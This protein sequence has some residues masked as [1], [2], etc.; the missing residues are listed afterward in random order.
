MKLPELSPFENIFI[1]LIVWFIAAIM[2]LWFLG[3]CSP[4][5]VTDD[6]PVVADEVPQVEVPTQT[7]Y[8][9]TATPEPAVVPVVPTDAVEPAPDC[10]AEYMMGLTVGHVPGLDVGEKKS[11]VVVSYGCLAFSIDFNGEAHLSGILAEDGLSLESCTFFADHTYPCKLEVRNLEPL[12]VRA[13]YD[14]KNGET[15]LICVARNNQ[16]H[17]DG[18]D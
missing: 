7:P 4:Q 6:S 5:V 14:N 10:P 13:T 8:V 12:K 9:I 11:P 15:F 17:I 3:A 16:A 2:V 1:K 18:C